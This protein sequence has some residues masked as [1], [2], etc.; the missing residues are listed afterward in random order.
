MSILA[1]NDAS[2]VEGALK[3]KERVLPKKQLTDAEEEEPK[4]CC[5]CSKTTLHASTDS[6]WDKKVGMGS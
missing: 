3:K 6:A 4:V 1:E 2:E 5:M